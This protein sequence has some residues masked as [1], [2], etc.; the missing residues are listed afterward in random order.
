LAFGDRLAH[1]RT[2]K[3]IITVADISAPYFTIQ[4]VALKL[5]PGEPTFFRDVDKVYEYVC[6]DEFVRYT[7]GRFNTMDEATQEILK[8]EELGYKD[9]FVVDVRK[10]QLTRTDYQPS[11]NA[12]GPL[13]GVNYTVQLAA[14]RF[15]VYVSEF[16]G[17]D[18]VFEYY[19]KDRIYRYCVGSFDGSVANV[20]LEKIKNMGY[21]DAFLVPQEKYEPF[22]IE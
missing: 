17:F 20:E 7:V 9:L 16:E 21:P 11:S 1:L 6:A 8:Y 2:N 5:P 3:K 4:M 22:R 19:M 13:A 14:Y 12:I 15:P 10:L 18:D